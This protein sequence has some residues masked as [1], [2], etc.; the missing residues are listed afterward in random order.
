M[1]ACAAYIFKDKRASVGESA[2][3]GSRINH[4]DGQPYPKLSHFPLI[5]FDPVVL[6]VSMP[7]YINNH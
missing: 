3:Y 2:R 4:F 5:R 7:F 6:D 1:V